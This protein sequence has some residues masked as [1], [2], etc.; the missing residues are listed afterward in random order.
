MIFEQDFKDFI[1]LLNQHQVDY[2]GYRRTRACLSWSAKTYRG[3]RYL[4]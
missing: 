3:F 2:M 4:D 1:E